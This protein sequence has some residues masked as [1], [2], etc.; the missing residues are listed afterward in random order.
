MSYCV[1]DL[2]SFVCLFVFIFLI[3]FYVYQVIAIKDVV[4][5]PSF[6][7]FSDVY[8]ATELMDTDLHNVLRSNQ[9]LSEEHCQVII[10]Y[11][12]LISFP[13]LCFVLIQFSNFVMVL[14]FSISCIR[15]FED[16]NIY[17]QQKLFTE[18]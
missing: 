4:P 8:I 12:T 16:W 15:Y 11:T 17:T 1:F 2:W 9:D 13:S 3:N 10:I 7:S 18:I 5:P 14:C 6:Q